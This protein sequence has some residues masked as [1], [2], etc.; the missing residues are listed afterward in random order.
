MKYNYSKENY[1][2]EEIGE[3]T[4][5]AIKGY[6]EGKCVL[7]IPDVFLDESEAEKYISLFNEQE[8]D[9]IHIYDVLEDIL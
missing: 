7:Y 2:H 1:Y 9:P 8:L 5:Y 3:Y 6:V 4:A